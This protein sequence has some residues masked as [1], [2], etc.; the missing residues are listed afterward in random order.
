MEGSVTPPP[1]VSPMG[2]PLQAAP[3]FNPIALSFKPPSFNVSTQSL[4]ITG[5]NRLVAIQN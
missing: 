3:Q 2:A 4:Q 1:A 5:A